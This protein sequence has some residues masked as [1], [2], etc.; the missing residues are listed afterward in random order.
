MNILHVSKFYPPVHGGIERFVQDLAQAQVRQGH[1]VFVAAHQP[2][3]NGKFES[4]D[5]MGVAVGLI[6]VVGK[7]LYTP[8]APRFTHYVQEL[9]AT[10]VPDVVHFHMPNPSAAFIAC[11]KW[12]KNFSKVIHWHSDIVFSDYDWRLKIAYAMY[13]P[14]EQQ[15]CRLADRIIATSQAYLDGSRALTRWRDKTTVVHLGL[16]SNRLSKTNGSI[17]PSPQPATWSPGRLRLLT[18][19]RLTY[20][21]GHRYLIDAVKDLDGVDL[22]IVGDGDLRGKLQSQIDQAN[23]NETISLL[24]NVDDEVVSTLLNSCDLFVLSSIEK[25]EAFG[26]VLLE[27]MAL[28]KPTAIFDIPGS[29]AGE[30]VVDGRTG[31]KLDLCDVDAMRQL[32]LSIDLND[33]ALERLGTCGLERFNQHF[34]IDQCAVNIDAV[35]REMAESG[36]HS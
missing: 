17:E 11:S 27:A 6:P 36:I 24:G 19:G 18:I 28:G 4:F 22:K 14:L 32:F 25:T 7:L 21:K 30:V 12:V 16:D 9:L 10:N 1:N 15:A 20:Y 29:G 31:Y 5:D 35:Y 26:L 34:H 23:A 13:R 8:I 3:R 33:T 2:R